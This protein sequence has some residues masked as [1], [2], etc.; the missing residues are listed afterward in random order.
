M[1]SYRYFILMGVSVFMLLWFILYSTGLAGLCARRANETLSQFF[2]RGVS[3]N[4]LMTGVGFFFLFSSILVAICIILFTPGIITRQFISRPLIYSHDNI[5]SSSNGNQNINKIINVFLPQLND[6]FNIYET[7][8]ECRQNKTI[9]N[10]K[11]RSQLLKLFLNF[12]LD[13]L[14]ST[15]KLVSSFSAMPF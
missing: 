6:S 10:L 1:I 7:I 3:A 8:N 11:S 5:S 2:H 12:D 13:D 15:K 4:L 9:L 14:V